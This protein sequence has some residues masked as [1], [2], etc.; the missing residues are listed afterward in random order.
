MHRSPAL[1]THA[2]L[3]YGRQVDGCTEFDPVTS[4][5]L[6][7]LG[8]HAGPGR[9]AA[10]YDVRR[11]NPHG[12]ASEARVGR[13]AFTLPTPSSRESNSPETNC[14]ILRRLIQMSYWFAQ[15][16]TL[17]LLRPPDR[18]TLRQAR[19]A[20]Q[21]GQ[22]AQNPGI[23]AIESRLYRQAAHSR[24]VRAPAPRH[25]TCRFRR[26]ASPRRCQGI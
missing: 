14:S 21:P 10:F 4:R 7:Y 3:A 11:R 18:F 24:G 9:G 15:P 8:C 5:G 12:V 25:L 13:L 23:R 6:D 2:T 26:H 16:H 17:V 1:A 19:P 20:E 22:F